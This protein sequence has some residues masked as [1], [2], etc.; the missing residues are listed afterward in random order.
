MHL[1][2]TR[3]HLTL[4]RATHSSFWLFELSVWLQVFSR[5]LI[6]VF[7]PIVLLQIG[8]S[9]EEVML[10]Y[11]IFFVV[12]VPLNFFSRWLIRKVGARKVVI[13]GLVF[14][15]AYFFALYNLGPDNWTLLLLIAIFAAIYDALYWVGNNFLLIKSSKHD[16]NVSK[17][18]GALQIVRQIAGILAPAFGALVL[19]FYNHQALIL[20]SVFILILSIIP[21]FYMKDVPDKPKRKQKTFREFFNSWDIYKDYLSIGCYGIHNVAE[22]I[23]WPIFIF[24]LFDSI[25]SVAALPIIISVSTIFFTLYASRIKKQDRAKVIGIASFILAL[26]WAFRIF[27][28]NTVFLYISVFFVGLFTILVGIPLASDICEKGEKKDTLSTATYWNT[29]SMLFKMILFGVMVLLV[30]VFQLSF[31]VAAISMFIILAVH[32]VLAPRLISPRT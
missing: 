14:L 2:N 22:S 16:D 11:L 20:I 32:S 1:F 23:I 21:L 18:L 13:A 5:S 19:I 31:T 28:D 3:H 6:A 29:A 10:Y 24:F 4:H 25:E 26:I 12:N 9:L 8:Y 7:I 17:D 15:I 27:V 30:N